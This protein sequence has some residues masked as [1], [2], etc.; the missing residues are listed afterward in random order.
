MASD[1]IGGTLVHG[2]RQVLEMIATGAPLASVLDELCR[3]IDERSKLMSAVFLLDDSGK[4]LRCV[5][6]PHL[7][8]PWRQLV[9]TAPLPLT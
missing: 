8:D 3:V 7:P 9:S 4:H 5:S 2:E 1:H 6:G